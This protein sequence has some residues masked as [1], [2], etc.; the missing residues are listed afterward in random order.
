MRVGTAKDARWQLQPHTKYCASCDILSL[1]P[2]P[3]PLPRPRPPLPRPPLPRL[4][5]PTGGRVAVM[6][7]WDGAGGC[8]REREDVRESDKANPHW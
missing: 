6:V 3:R 7:R 1:P 8:E 5:I 4:F 2:R